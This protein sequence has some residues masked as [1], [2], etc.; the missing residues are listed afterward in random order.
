MSDGIPCES[1]YY[2]DGSVNPTKQL[3]KNNKAF[4]T[5]KGNCKKNGYNKDTR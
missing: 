3:A 5:L 2:N 1:S 4:E